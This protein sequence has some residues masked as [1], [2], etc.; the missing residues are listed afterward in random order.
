VSNNLHSIRDI[1]KLLRK[2]LS[3]LYYEKEIDSVTNIIIKTL[4]G[5]NRLHRFADP[6]MKVPP[7]IGGQVNEIVA[8]L[9]KG[10]PLQY[11]LKKTEF[12][13]NPIKLN[14][15]VLIPRQE[16]EELVDLIIK[17]N[18]G[19][20]GKIIDFC[21]GSG[22]IAIALARNLPGA[23][24]TATDISEEAVKLAGE[25]A[26]LNNV[27]VGFVISDLFGKIP[28]TLYHADIIVS[29]PPYVRESEKRLM[30]KNVLDF[31]P[32]A[33]LFVPDDDPLK[34]YHRLL[35]IS[36]MVLK[37]GGRVYFE[38]NEAMGKELEYLMR[39]SGLTAI[40]VIKDLNGRDRIIKGELNG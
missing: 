18:R 28:E 32:H 5:T 25:N 30:H 17:E 31:E 39:Q 36:G 23:V 22:C 14:E 13:S 2:E 29:N 12:Y 4:F 1:R 8:E 9:L 34:F 33:A 40:K 21:T 38:I 7:E 24:I 11:V 10:K 16:T 19:F 3:D 6:E 20:S 26:L 27:S 35:G 37:T 15:Y